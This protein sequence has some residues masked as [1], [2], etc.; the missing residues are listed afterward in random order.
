VSALLRHSPARD[1]AWGRFYARRRSARVLHEAVAA[2]SQQ[3]RLA[4]YYADLSRAPDFHPV[5]H[6]ARA[7]RGLQLVSPTGV[8]PERRQHPALANPESLPA[9]GQQAPIT[10][11]RKRAKESK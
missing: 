10:K 11:P 3:E 8:Q 7:A 9:S 2:P 5:A 6:A 1:Q 4:R